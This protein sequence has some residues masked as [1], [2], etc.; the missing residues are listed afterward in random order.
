MVMCIHQAIGEEAD[1]G[2]GNVFFKEFQKHALVKIIRPLD[3]I[4]L[5]GVPLLLFFVIFPLATPFSLIHTS[6]CKKQVLSAGRCKMRFFD[7][8]KPKW[9]HT[10]W[11]KRWRAV[12]KITNQSILMK[13]AKTDKDTSIRKAAVEG[14]ADQALLTNL[15]NST[16]NS[17]TKLEVCY[18][19]E[20]KSLAQSVY[21]YIARNDIDW[22]MRKVAYEKLGNEQA[23]LDEV[24]NNDE[25]LIKIKND[26]LNESTRWKAVEYF[27]T[28]SNFS[29]LQTESIFNRIMDKDSLLRILKIALLNISPTLEP[30]H[31]LRYIGMETVLKCNEIDHVPER[32]VSEPVYE[33]IWTEVENPTFVLLRDVIKSIEYTK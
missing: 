24:A 30:K 1:T 9:K 5:M 29:I 7:L 21:C 20:D 28:F 33:D 18:K 12:N 4:L 15:V 11:K 2:E 3:S 23:A 19:L 6:I 10:D 26:N 17:D 22:R 25:N 14:I 16:Q 32:W 13:I 27:L 31:E 8:F